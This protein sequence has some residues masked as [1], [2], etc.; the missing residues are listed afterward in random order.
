MDKLHIDK[1]SGAA[2]KILE[3]LPKPDRSPDDPAGK[4]LISTF[5]P[6]PCFPLGTAYRSLLR[7]P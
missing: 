1:E 6:L 7:P 2:E 3:K 5:P 4:Q